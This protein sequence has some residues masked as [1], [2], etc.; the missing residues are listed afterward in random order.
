MCRASMPCLSAAMRHTCAQTLLLAHGSPGHP[1][2]QCFA[3]YTHFACLLIM[4]VGGL[5]APKTLAQG[6][7]ASSSRTSLCSVSCASWKQSAVAL[8][9]HQLQGCCTGSKVCHNLRKS[10]RKSLWETKGKRSMTLSLCAGRVCQ[11]RGCDG[12]TC[13][14]S[15]QTSS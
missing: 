1:S 7:T 4:H 3:S 5:S 15:P 14:P 8:V 13:P 9:H 11:G 6:K 2:A 10:L 12:G